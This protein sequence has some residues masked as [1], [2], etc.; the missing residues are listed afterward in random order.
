MSNT[1]TAGGTE[2]DLATARESR[3]VRLHEGTLRTE[4]SP[5]RPHTLHTLATRTSWTL[6]GS[7]WGRACLRD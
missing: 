6:S 4:R 2:P 5:A 3:G 1:G 7:V